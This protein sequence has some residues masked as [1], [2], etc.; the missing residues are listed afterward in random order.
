MRDFIAAIEDALGKKARFELLPMQPGDVEATWA[1]TA[2]LTAVTG[3]SPNTPLRE[4]IA[5][6]AAWYREYYR[7]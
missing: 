7:I 6:F 1:D 4:G 2:D 3:F 5:R